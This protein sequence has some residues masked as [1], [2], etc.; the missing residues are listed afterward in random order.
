MSLG[1]RLRE[2]RENRGLYQKDVATEIGV[3]PGAISYYEKDIKKP[4]REVLDKLAN[5][6][7]VT[8]DFLLNGKDNTLSDIEEKFPE[9]VQILR[10]ASYELFEEDKKKMIKL[11]KAFL[12]ED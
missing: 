7:G 2:L 11:I 5:F 9:G 8:T 3:S 1:S 4:G 6:Y 12:G 10:R